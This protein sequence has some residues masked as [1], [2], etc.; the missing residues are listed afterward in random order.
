MHA[1]EPRRFASPHAAAFDL[2]GTLQALK[3]RAIPSDIAPAVVFLAS[4]AAGWI[5]GS[6]LNVDGGH[7]RH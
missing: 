1:G 2:V 3:R 5:T 6:T 4:E 7:I